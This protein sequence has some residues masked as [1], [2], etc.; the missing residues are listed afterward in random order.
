[1]HDVLRSR[2]MRRIESLPEAQVYQVLDYI[3][4]LESKYG[5]ADL[6]ARA[7]GLQ[8]LAENLEDRLRKRSF[9]PASVREAFQ[10]FAVADRA[11]SSVARA[12]RRMLSELSGE[13]DEQPTPD[14]RA[15]G[16][17]APLPR[18]PEPGSEDVRERSS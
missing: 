8:R 2:L 16:D 3:E 12:G 11:M 1:M 15:S 5:A 9:N 10:V 17:D 18:D 7:G 6:E 14:A 4:F 13:T